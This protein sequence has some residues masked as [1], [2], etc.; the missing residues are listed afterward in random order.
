[1]NSSRRLTHRIHRVAELFQESSG[2]KAGLCLELA[3]F[4]S[5]LLSCCCVGGAPCTAAPGG[6]M[7]WWPGD[8]FV[9]DIVGTNN[10]FLQ[11]GATSGA[12][13]LIGSGFGFDGTNNYVQ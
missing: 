7:G 11:G 2:I 6:L 4:L 10:A 12:T 9:T 5:L 3:I 13:G 8:G 1:M